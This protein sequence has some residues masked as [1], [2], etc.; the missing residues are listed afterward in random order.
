M[1]FDNFNVE[2]NNEVE[3]EVVAEVKTRK[4]Q[5]AVRSANPLAHRKKDDSKPAETFMLDIKEEKSAEKPLDINQS[6]K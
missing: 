6:K 2:E 4:K 5:E 1:Q 3:E